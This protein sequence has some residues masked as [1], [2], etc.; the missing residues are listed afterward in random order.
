MKVTINLTSIFH[1]Q[2]LYSYKSRFINRWVVILNFSRMIPNVVT[3]DQIVWIIWRIPRNPGHWVSLIKINFCFG[4]D[5]TNNIICIRLGYSWQL[6]GQIQH[7]QW[8]L[9]SHLSTECPHLRSLV[10]TAL[11]YVCTRWNTLTSTNRNIVNRIMVE[12]VYDHVIYI[13]RHFHRKPCENFI[14]SSL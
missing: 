3:H 8:D 2:F 11:C 6:K 10:I 13:S 9:K 1:R 12:L 7:V 4:D 14:S 5:P